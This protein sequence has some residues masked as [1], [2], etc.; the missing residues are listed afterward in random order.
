GWEVDDVTIV[1]RLCSP[2]PGGLVVGHVT[3]ATTGKFVAGATVASPDKP[4]EK[5]ATNGDGFYWIFST[6]T[7]AHTFT[8]AKSGYSS[9]SKAVTV[10]PDAAVGADLA[11]GSARLAATPSR[12]EAF[13]TLGGTRT[14]TVNVKNTGT[15]PATVTV[16]ERGGPTIP[17]M[18]NKAAAQTIDVGHVSKGVT[19]SGKTADPGKPAAK[20]GAKRPAV[21]AVADPAWA[22]IADHTMP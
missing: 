21:K 9:A 15:A 8:A 13:V 12:I 22:P 1:N 16:A 5:A 7:G 2:V 10:T 20:P 3:D 4:D 19:P 14:A 6:L 18:Q 17:T 11:L